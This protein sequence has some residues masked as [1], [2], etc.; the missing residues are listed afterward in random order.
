MASGAERMFARLGRKPENTTRPSRPNTPCNAYPN[1]FFLTGTGNLN[2]ILSE[3]QQGL[4]IPDFVLKNGHDFRI[5]RSLLDFK[6]RE[7]GTAEAINRLYGAGLIKQED[8]ARFVLAFA[9]ADGKAKLHPMAQMT[10]YDLDRAEEKLKGKDG[11]GCIGKLEQVMTEI[12]NLIAEAATNPRLQNNPAIKQVQEVLHRGASWFTE[13]DIIGSKFYTTEPGPYHLPLGTLENGPK[14]YYKGEKGLVTIAPPGSGKT[15]CNVLP[16][17][18]AWRGSV[19]VLDVKGECYAETADLRREFS[20]VYK[21]APFSPDES[22]C[23]NPLDAIDANPDFLWQSARLVAEDLVVTGTSS[24]PYWDN[25]GRDFLLSF[26]AYVKLYRP[27]LRQNMSEVMDIAS[28][29][30]E[31]FSKITDQMAQ[32]DLGALRRQGNT[33]KSLLT[34]NPKVAET[35]LD[36][37]RAQLSIWEEHA[38]SRITFRSD[39]QP[40]ALRERPISVYLIIPPAAVDTYASALRTI[41]SAHVRHLMPHDDPHAGP[42]PVLFLLD[43]MP[44]LGRMAPIA[45]A[46]DTGRGYGIKLWMFAQNMGQLEGAYGKQADGMINSADVKIYMNIGNDIAPRLSRDLG[47]REA[48]LEGQKRPL[49]EPTDLTGRQFRDWQLAIASNELPAR[50]SKDMF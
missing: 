18:A 13:A 40:S 8:F 45:T 9:W 21:F 20:E 24:D 5:E 39:W 35:A 14:L 19:I 27:T 26:L 30:P 4:Y 28:S 41:I 34:N 48:L 47:T 7:R 23:F 42:C 16:A 10:L 1:D 3:W 31:E 25:R 49:A 37:L 33:F 2:V 15:R 12:T 32:S 17:L 50:L 6:E 11:K 38:L 44:R 43:E 46:L 22:S 36:N 29:P